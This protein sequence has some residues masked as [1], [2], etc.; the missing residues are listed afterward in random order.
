M[1]RYYNCLPNPMYSEYK[2]KT[3]NLK[4][5]AFIFSLLFSFFFFF[6]FSLTSDSD[7]IFSI[8]LS[9]CMVYSANRLCNTYCP[10]F[11][12]VSITMVDAMLGS[13]SAGSVTW[14]QGRER[15]SDVVLVARLSVDP[16]LNGWNK[17]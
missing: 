5:P 6:S 10:G 9:A 11:T 1:V 13:R 16:M 14:I 2:W 12:L 4:Q 8:F 3:F 17:G 7:M 15:V